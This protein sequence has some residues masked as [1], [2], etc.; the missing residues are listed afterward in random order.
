MPPQVTPVYGGRK[1]RRG[2]RLRDMFTNYINFRASKKYGTKRRWPRAVKAAPYGE[3][4]SIR[5]RQHI[6]RNRCNMPKRD[7]YWSNLAPKT[8]FH[9]TDKVSAYNYVGTSAAVA[10]TGQFDHDSPY[11]GCAVSALM[12]KSDLPYLYGMAAG[13]WN[14]QGPEVSSDA[15]AGWAPLLNKAGWDEA[16]NDKAE[17]DINL[18]FYIENIS[19][20]D[21]I[22]NSC[23]LTQQFKVYI[24]RPKRFP[25]PTANTVLDNFNKVGSLDTSTTDST[26]GDI[27]GTDGNGNV[28]TQTNRTYCHTFGWNPS[29]SKELMHHFKVKMI[30]NFVLKP[31]ESYTY[32]IRQPNK[33][34][35]YARTAAQHENVYPGLSSYV[36]VIAKT[37]L[38]GDKTT[39]NG[40]N[41][42]N[43]GHGSGQYQHTRMRRFKLFTFPIMTNVK[44]GSNS[45]N[46]VAWANQ[47]IINVE[48]GSADQGQEEL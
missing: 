13:G 40:V 44:I 8:L 37:Q 41:S 9:S 24:L 27:L 10:V 3:N 38:V 21:T 36:L 45:L 26:F 5:G 32:G 6:I 33:F 43:F 22:V 39:T 34:L 30:E 2:E 4:M 28:I 14:N 1:R 19:I 16:V 48:T 20:R 29:D 31:G 12:P 46:A 11:Q 35:I 42:T 7:K 23:S 17:R 25:C 47:E 18:R 15:G